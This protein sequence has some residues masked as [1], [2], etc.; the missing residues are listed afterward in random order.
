MSETPRLSQRQERPVQ[1]GTWLVMGSVVYGIV[2]VIVFIVVD[3]S[4]PVAWLLTTPTW[5]MM[6]AIVLLGRMLSMS[7]PPFD[8]IRWYDFFLPWK[9]LPPDEERA[10]P[11]VNDRL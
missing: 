10:N 9:K 7:G 8:R 2:M 4:T 5:V 11:D 3:P 1:I 6:I